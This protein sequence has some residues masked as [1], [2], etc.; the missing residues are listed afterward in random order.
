MLYICSCAFLSL[1]H[2]DLLLMLP[3]MSASHSHRDRLVSL[4]PANRALN[5]EEEWRNEGIKLEQ[6]HSC[7]EKNQG[8]FFAPN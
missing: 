5:E 6:L 8:G 1:E 3:H 4:W 2:N 7:G